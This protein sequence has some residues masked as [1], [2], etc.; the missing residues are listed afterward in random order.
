VGASANALA[1]GF[2]LLTGGPPAKES[3]TISARTNPLVG[4]YR[5]ADSR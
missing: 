2:A 1:V 5:T 3:S 4:N